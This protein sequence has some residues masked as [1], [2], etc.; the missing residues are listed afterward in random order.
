MSEGKAKTEK[1]HILAVLQDGSL[2]NAH[3]I[4]FRL[5]KSF[6]LKPKLNSLRKNLQRCVKQGIVERV[7]NRGSYHYEISEKGRKRLGII[8]AKKVKDFEKR[9][10]GLGK[11]GGLQRY[12]GEQ[13]KLEEKWLFDRSI[14]AVNTIK[15]C[16]C[17]L[18]L[19]GDKMIL[20]WARSTKLYWQWEIQ[21]LIPDLPLYMVMAIEQMLCKRVVSNKTQIT[22]IEIFPL[23]NLVRRRSDESYYLFHS[24]KEEQNETEKYKRLYEEKR[25]QF[26]NLKKPLELIKDSENA[27]EIH[28]Y[29]KDL[30]LAHDL[31]KLEAKSEQVI[32]QGKLIS[33]LLQ[34]RLSRKQ[35]DD[36]AFH[37]ILL[38]R[39]INWR[40]WD[41][42][43]PAYD[44][45]SLS[46]RGSARL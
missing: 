25:V 7:K 2:E 32:S 42:L 6:G 40:W 17:V 33:S 41:L 37:A 16:D 21:K 10:E 23:I 15:L 36:E 24:L 27:R 18:T 38:R 39:Y 35:K 19:S 45:P 5:E 31:G 44:S 11:R 34:D 28:S 13:E 22:G 8:K 9:P 20:D 1:M 46:L 43:P 12:W 29:S 30:K 14:E 3:G 4:S 26:E